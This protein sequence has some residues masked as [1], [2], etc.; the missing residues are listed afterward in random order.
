MVLIERN[1]TF[2]ACFPFAGRLDRIFREATRLPGRKPWAGRKRR[3]FERYLQAR[4]DTGSQLLPR[5]AFTH[6]GR[7]AFIYLLFIKALL[8][9]KAAGI[10]I[11]NWFKD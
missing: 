1:W 4:L 3:L 6:V 8:F 2:M 5:P 10:P 7:S 9:G 11:S